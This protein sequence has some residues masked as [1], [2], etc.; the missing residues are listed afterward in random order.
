MTSV[1]CWEGSSSIFSWNE[2]GRA[3]T[4]INHMIEPGGCSVVYGICFDCASDCVE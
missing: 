2:T 3:T 1:T 4:L